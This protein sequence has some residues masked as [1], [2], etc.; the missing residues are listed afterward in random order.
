MTDEEDKPLHSSDSEF[1][2]PKN[3]QKHKHLQSQTDLISLHPGPPKHRHGLTNAKVEK[4]CKRQTSN[5][6][7]HLFRSPS[8]NGLTDQ[9]SVI[10]PNKLPKNIPVTEN[11]T[12][13]VTSGNQKSSTF[14]TTEYS[15]NLGN[16]PLE[17]LLLTLEARLEISPNQESFIQELAK[18]N[19]SANR[20]AAVVYLL[21]HNSHK[22]D[23]LGESISKLQGI[24]TSGGDLSQR[25]KMI[26][27]QT[28]FWTKPP[29]VTIF[30]DLIRV[31]LHQFF[32]SAEV[33]SYTKGTDSGSIVIGKSLFSMTM[34]KK[35]LPIPFGD[36]DNEARLIVATEVRCILKQERNL[37]KKKIMKNIFVREGNPEQPIPRL[38]EL[39]K[40]LFEWASHKGTSYSNKEIKEKFN[41]SKL[42]Q[43]FALLRVCA[44]YQQFHKCEAPWPVVDEQ[45][46]NLKKHSTTFRNA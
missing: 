9:G 43:R 18:L 27:A 34:K 26:G 32:I 20:H 41:N 11:N 35:Y 13:S 24:Y 44:T 19:T 12:N 23:L 36:E 46:E 15:E 2:H 25:E 22:M 31:M 33:E 38:I 45:L 10:E 17:L 6:N 37:F 40:L 7:S 21:M 39:T 1:L 14:S 42:R 4:F 8:E 3:L 16:N 5:F 28:F 30:Q 29:K